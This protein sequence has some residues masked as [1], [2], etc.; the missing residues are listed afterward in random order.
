M[1][2]WMYLALFIALML[3]EVT[4]ERH[5]AHIS[6]QGLRAT[7]DFVPL[8]A[9]VNI[10]VTLNCENCVASGD[11]FLWSIHEYPM[12][13]DRDM[14]CSEDNIGPMFSEGGGSLS[15]THGLLTGTAL[16][17]GP[18][19]F[20]NSDVSFEGM[21]SISGRALLF[22]KSTGSVRYCASIIPVGEMLTAVST[23]QYPVAG[24]VTFRQ[25]IGQ[26]VTLGTSI[27]VDLDII[28]SPQTIRN[29]DWQIRSNSGITVD[30]DLEQQCE[31]VD[32]EPVYDLSTKFGSLIIRTV[33]NHQ[34]YYFF[35]PDLSLEGDNSVVDMSLVLSYP[36]GSLA[37]CNKINTLA[38][39]S[40]QTKISAKNITGVIS[41][42][43]RS[44]WDYTSVNVELANLRSLIGGYH[45]HEYP[46][47][48]R[49][50]ADDNLASSDAVAGHFNP[51]GVTDFPN[52]TVGTEDQYEIGD[53]SNKFGFLTNKE[54][55][56]E[57]Y[58][59]WNMPL[60]GTNSIAG[61]SIVLHLSEDGSRYAYGQISYP[62]E[63]IKTV[64]VDFQAPVTGS[65]VMKQ[66]QN[67][68]L[69][70]TTVFVDIANVDGTSTVE[71]NWHVH[72]YKINNDYIAETGRCN[73]NGGHYN[74][75]KVDLDDGYS[76]CSPS[77]PRR[78]EA[79]DFSGKHGNLNIASMLHTSDGK[80]FFTDV[81]LP[82][83]GIYSIDE[84]SVVIHV[85]DAGAGRLAC[86]NTF[87]IL[88][89][90]VSTTT[91]SDTAIL[92]SIVFDQEGLNDPTSVSVE[93][94]GLSNMANGWHVHVLPVP[95]GEENECS[96]T[97]GHFNPFN[98]MG[99]PPSSTLDLYEVGD[100]SG[101]FVTLE[102]RTE[103]SETFV[104]QT[105]TLRG[106][107][108]IDARSIVVHRN[109]AV[110]SRWSCSTLK[111][112]LH[113][114]SFGVTAIAVFQNDAVSGT[115]TFRQ[116]HQG[117]DY[118]AD[119]IID[120][121]LDLSD[122]VSEEV[123]SWSVLDATDVSDCNYG[124]QVY[125][126]F[127]IQD[128][129]AKCSLARQGQCIM[130]NLGGRHGVIPDGGAIFTDTNLPL[131]GQLPNIG[132]ILRLEVGGEVYCSQV[133]PIEEQGKRIT[134]SFPSSVE[135]DPYEF[136]LA[137]STGVDGVEMWQIVV[138]ESETNDHP[139]IEGCQSVDFWVIGEDVDQLAENIDEAT[140]L[141]EYNPVQCLEIEPTTPTP[142]HASTIKAY[143]VRS[144]LSFVISF[145]VFFHVT[146]RAH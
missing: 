109:D 85:V 72:M 122:S 35:D 117:N 60:F 54:T 4:A 53:I 76:D 81:Q 89:K 17:D 11:T 13:Y 31:A 43:Q 144:C 79:G 101:K 107:H 46:I 63:N 78:C 73:A 6:I 47:P 141:G 71:H 7:V 108:S 126:P 121:A 88:K 99:S 90:T 48:L 95:Y 137:I 16:N 132:R 23:F 49:Y 33:S 92:G 113:P 120:A 87:G 105:I 138:P 61:R 114:L 14:P 93:I 36:N 131:I 69:S 139:T 96:L 106:P 25:Q 32:D 26:A 116:T 2:S 112:V 97:L 146:I 22:E 84:R 41:F 8:E 136:R 24:T 44:P 77:N 42:S 34:A 128:D 40:V 133:Q 20:L 50:F 94:S 111:E 19:S 118:L 98:I 45:V 65:I 134:W 125:D 143:T 9:Q 56:A 68:P 66:D 64:V 58:T 57:V 12:L 103:L 70:E 5:V 59:D 27:Y 52:A 37:T 110:G 1:V 145:I 124:S 15:N 127:N 75:F 3:N 62:T 82:L 21:N 86:Q 115:V 129:A 91:W 130:G 142:N 28:S 38:P 80:F 83:S 140:D 104:D 30:M 18:Q 74:P 55:I 102:D 135:F 119:T 67:D 29:L 51:Y 39:R 10:T 123:S 100:L